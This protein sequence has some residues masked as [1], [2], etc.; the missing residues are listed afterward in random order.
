M[1][2][3]IETFTASTVYKASTAPIFKGVLWENLKLFYL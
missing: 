3:Y 1:K 2:P